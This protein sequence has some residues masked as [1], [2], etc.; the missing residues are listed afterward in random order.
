MNF[1]F[2]K[3]T[4]RP[5]CSP[6]PNLLRGTNVTINEHEFFQER[7]I[8][9]PQM[10]GNTVK[11]KSRYQ[12]RAKS[13]VWREFLQCDCYPLDVNYP[14]DGLCKNGKI[15]LSRGVG[16]DTSFFIHEEHGNGEYDVV[17]HIYF[18]RENFKGPSKCRSAVRYMGAGSKRFISTFA[19]SIKN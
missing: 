4:K 13:P 1:P 3:R 9:I 2:A 8:V 16:G 19:P 12:F 17:A 18:P 6:Y 10:S 15:T 11:A 5:L 7:N 14:L